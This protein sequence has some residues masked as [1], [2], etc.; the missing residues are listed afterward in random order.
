MQMESE[1]LGH[2]LHTLPP[3]AWHQP[4]A[5]QGWAVHDVVGHLI[6]GAELYTKVVTRGLRGEATPLDGWPTAGSVNAASAAPLLA[7]LSVARRQELGKELLPTFDA[8]STQLQQ[9]LAGVYPQAWETACY[10]LA[11]VLPVRFF[12]DL[13]LTE[14]VMHGWDICSRVEPGATLTPASLP[15]FLDVLTTAIG[16]AF[17]PGT[18]LPRPVRYRFVLTGT[19]DR[20]LDIVVSKEGARLQASST[21]H[22][23]VLYRCCPETFVLVMYGRLSMTDALA[24]GR[25]HVDGDTTLVTAFSQCFRGV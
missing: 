7:Q 8:T 12:V 5:C 4:S 9:V 25:V 6:V 17:W 21:D 19:P 14:L 20:C 1:R 24:Q 16:W 11:G 23:H 15:A 2:Y 3:Q 18:P 22:S 13:R 10:H